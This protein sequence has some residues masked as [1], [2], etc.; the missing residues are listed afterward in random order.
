MWNLNLNKL[1]NKTKRRRFT[2]IEN[3]VVVIS[4][5][6]GEGNTGEGAWEGQTTGVR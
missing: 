4:G 2:D 5:E 1:V 3:R 6:G